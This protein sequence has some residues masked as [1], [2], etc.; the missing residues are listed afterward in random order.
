MD[1]DPLE[2]EL[3]DEQAAELDRRSD[4]EDA[5]PDAALPW[6]DAKA[7]A[8]A[9]MRDRG[10]NSAQFAEPEEDLANDLIV[11]SPRFRAL[12][13]KSLASGREPFPFAD[14]LD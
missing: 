9:R 5:A 2:W 1:S 13:E 6:E 10:P 14:L 4:E 7:Q 12:L 11:H 8:L 3:T